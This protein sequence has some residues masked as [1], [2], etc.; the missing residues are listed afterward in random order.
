MKYIKKIFFKL[1]KSYIFQ[2][3]YSSFEH[4]NK[5]WKVIYNNDYKNIEPNKDSPSRKKHL[6]FLYN[7]PSLKMSHF[8]KKFK[9]NRYLVVDIGSGDGWLSAKLSKFFKKIIAIETSKEA[10]KLAK[11][12]Y[13]KHSNINWING[14]A[15]DCISKIEFKKPVLFTSLHVLSHLTDNQVLKICKIINSKNI[16]K[17]SI[18]NFSELYTKV[19]SI[20]KYMNTSRSIKWW[21]K[22]LSNWR[23]DFHGPVISKIKN[24]KRHKGFWGH[25]II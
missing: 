23:L 20:R 2:N 10:V 13:K 22:N 17:N 7:Q 25:K 14:F 8:L 16:P 18:L 24:E 21:S 11:K 1:L 4:H 19:N 3:K 15:E 5:D 6:H 9:K 12:R